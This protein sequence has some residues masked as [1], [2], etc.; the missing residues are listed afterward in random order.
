MALRLMQGHQPSAL[1]FRGAPALG[2]A[3][4]CDDGG[5]N[6]SFA[7]TYCS[8]VRDD[9]M[10]SAKPQ[11]LSS[12]ATERKDKE[13][14]RIEVA[15]LQGMTKQDIRRINARLDQCETDTF[16]QD[17]ETENNNA[18]LELVNQDKTAL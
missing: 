10:A 5:D 14:L 9:A 18:E 1:S 12:I 15:M 13:A 16:A 2:R 11:R 4:V 8:R 6:G 3:G 17:V 7:P